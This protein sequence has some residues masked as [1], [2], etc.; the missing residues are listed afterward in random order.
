MKSF[1]LTL[2]LLM[3]GTGSL[4]D[5][6]VLGGSLQFTMWLMGLSMLVSSS[7]SV[8]GFPLLLTGWAWGVSTSVELGH[9]D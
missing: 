7:L 9:F 3:P 8:L 4:A 1:L 5:G 6:K 2:N